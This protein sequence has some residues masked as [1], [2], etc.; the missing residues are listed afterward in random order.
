VTVGVGVD[1]R[2]GERCQ[3][4]KT[5]GIQLTWL[6]PVRRTAGGSETMKVVTE[7]TETRI[8]RV[9]PSNSV[10]EIFRQV[11]ERL[12]VREGKVVRAVHDGLHQQRINTVVADGLWDGCIHVYKLYLDEW[13][14]LDQRV[15]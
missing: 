11:V 15:L 10:A 1:V 2:G 12:R 6:K 7:Q 8:G 3:K 4:T 13:L 9:E 5:F 14:Y